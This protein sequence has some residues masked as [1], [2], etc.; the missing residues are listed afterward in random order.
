M[1]RT[2]CGRAPGSRGVWASSLPRLAE[3][4]ERS[5]PGRVF[6]QRRS[7]AL[8][9]S[10]VGLGATGVR[11]PGSLGC[12]RPASGGGGACAV[13]RQPTYGGGGTCLGGVASGDGGAL[14][15]E[16]IGDQSWA[17]PELGLG[18]SY[19]GVRSLAGGARRREIY[20][21]GRETTA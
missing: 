9:G 14:A 4:G 18:A 20:G 6:C 3:K 12:C 16:S 19:G 2:T 13:G 1:K 11:G 7:L 8:G 15:R 5:R 10:G 21:R 17:T